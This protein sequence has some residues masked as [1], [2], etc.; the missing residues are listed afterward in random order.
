MYPLYQD[1][2]TH[3]M[4]GKSKLPFF[5]VHHTLHVSY[6]AHHHC[7]AELSM[8]VQG[9]GTE[10]LN[11]HPYAIRRG[12]VSFLLPH[13]IHEIHIEQVPVE[14]YNC[15]FDLNLVLTD[16]N[17]H[18]LG[19]MLLQTGNELPSHFELGEEL[20]LYLEKIMMQLTQEYNSNQPAKDTIIK[21]KLQEALVFL[22][23][24]QAISEKTNRA[25]TDSSNTHILEILMYLHLHYQEDVNLNS[26]A[27]LFNWNASYLSRLFHRYVGKTFTDYLHILRV[28]QAATLLATTSMKVTD[29]STEVGFDHIR[30]FTRVFKKM[31]GMIPSDYRRQ[32]QSLVNEMKRFEA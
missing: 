22:V 9:S 23:R 31:K 19:K 5:I 20:T 7:F 29:I 3:L 25:V 6:P 18:E 30:T 2:I 13:H 21:S 10:V 12:T 4:Y 27:K 26:L 16:P 24:S 8:V 11:G 15:L 14:K 17:N 32:Q 28:G 1:L